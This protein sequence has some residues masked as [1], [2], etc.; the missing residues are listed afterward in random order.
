MGREAHALGICLRTALVALLLA[1]PVSG[2]LAQGARED[3]PARRAIMKAQALLK[4]VA[5][6]KAAL[7]QQNLE[8]Q[9]AQRKVEKALAASEQRL[10]ETEQAL[11]QAKAR[12]A[13]LEATLGRTEATLDS[14][15]ERLED[16][17]Q[18]L[19]ETT[20]FLRRTLN[21]KQQVVLDTAATID[22][23]SREMLDCE[24]KNV[25]LFEANAELMQAYEDKDALDAL[26]QREKFTGIRQVAVENLL[27]EYQF[28]IEDAS[29]TRPTV[30]K[31]ESLMRELE[32]LQ[33]EATPGG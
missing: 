4:R 28:K 3:D 23:Q 13:S 22:L 15:R 11:E 17:R 6:E 33:G 19:G 1:A 14:T 29:Y 2:A 27:Q 16:T 24:A 8:L 9:A 18:R 25:A 10:A 5:A 20:R 31:P 26:L 30:E 7:E 12:G 32:A 21:E